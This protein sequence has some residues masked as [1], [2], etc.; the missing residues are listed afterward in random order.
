MTTW[1]KTSAIYSL[2]P[3]TFSDSNN[4]G[5]G[6]LD[7]IVARLDHL[8]W[9][10][11]DAVWL[12]PI[13]PSPMLDAGYDIQDFCGINGKFG[14]LAAFDR[15][16]AE[17]HRRGMRLILDFVPNHTSD[18]HPW[19]LE[20]RSSR[21]NPKRDWYIWRDAK[22]D[23]SPPTNWIDHRK[24]C[25]WSWDEG[26][27]QYYYHLFLPEQPDLNLRNPDVV[28]AI[29]EV[30]AFWM[31]RGVDGFRLDAAMNLVEDELFRD[32][33]MDDDIAN[34]PPGW[35]D[36]LF[37]SDRPETHRVIAGFRRT[38][39]GYP[40]RLFVGE[41]IAP[42]V[43]MMEYYGRREPG[44]HMPFNNQIMKT[45]PWAARKI[46]AAIDQYMILLP[47]GAW[48]NWVLGSHDVSRAATRLGPEQAR[49]AAMLQLTLPG[50]AFIYYGEEIGLGDAE[51]PPD[52]IR[53]PYEAYGQGR[54]P[55]RAP[56]PW[57]SDAHGG[58]SGV[59]PWLPLA[60]DYPTRNVAALRADP[61]SIL[62][63][64]RALL[65]LRRDKPALQTETYRPLRAEGDLLMFMRPHEQESLAV[66][67]NLGSAQQEALLP[68]RGRIILSTKL[69]RAEAAEGRL[70][71]RPDEGV[72]VAL[73]GKSPA[74]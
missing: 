39:D 38:I 1:W 4:D 66:V 55:Y 28:A 61:G 65:A 16:V 50:T 69:D 3:A 51:V 5:Y 71:L 2:F 9:L 52:R 53:D 45:E 40:E 21:D 26:T 22:P 49:V 58:F 23:G 29:E 42:L 70:V 32:E 67:L 60:A 54:D 20:S 63:L 43:R 25:A 27:A 37:T 47:D 7:G 57:A 30:L 34:G 48:P 8:A 18:R 44:F 73:S 33:P 36:H 56:M 72:V 31:E 59:E 64:Y 46:E 41:V 19:F 62:H 17:L 14:D 6:D 13:Y 35:M 12:G 24:E 74:G 68:G 10:G 15:L 11:I